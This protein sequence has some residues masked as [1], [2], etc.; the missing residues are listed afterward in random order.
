MQTVEA[1]LKNKAK[2][3][4][5]LYIDKSKGIVSDEDYLTISFTLQEERQQLELRKKILKR[6]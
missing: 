1:D 6:R 4:T 3:L 2:V 5:N